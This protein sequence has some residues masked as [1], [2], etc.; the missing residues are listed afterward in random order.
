MLSN[1]DKP[2]SLGEH[3]RRIRDTDADDDLQGTV[4]DAISF[5]LRM[6]SDEE[7]YEALDLVLREEATVLEDDYFA[8]EYH[9]ES[10]SESLYESLKDIENPKKDSKFHPLADAV[11]RNHLECVKLLL[12]KGAPSGTDLWTSVDA[13]MPL[14]VAVAKQNEQALKLL[15]RADDAVFVNVYK[16][17][18]PLHVAVKMGWEKGVEL[19]CSHPD[20][21]TSV[22]FLATECLGECTPLHLAAR[23]ADVRMYR[24]LVRGGLD[25][26]L[27]DEDGLSPKDIMKALTKVN[28]KKRSVSTS[29]RDPEASAT[30]RTRCC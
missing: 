16:G 22:E 6:T 21:V 23:A 8:P 29:H 9:S 28:K 12:A 13:R 17:A 26:A 3:L 27:C 24:L 10:L 15:L 5:A 14:H 4:L 7:A 25:E 20:V 11:A 1:L 2:E 30:A 18:T 19:L